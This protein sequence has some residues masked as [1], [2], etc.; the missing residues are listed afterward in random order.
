MGFCGN[1]LVHENI[2]PRSSELLAA[3]FI[4][5]W[6]Q[7][8][9]AR[10]GCLF[11]CKA[12]QKTCS[13]L[14]MNHLFDQICCRSGRQNID[15]R[16]MESIPFFLFEKRRW[17]ILPNAPANVLVSIGTCG[18]VLI[19][20][21]RRGDHLPPPHHPISVAL[22]ILPS[23]HLPSTNFVFKLCYPGYQRQKGKFNSGRLPLILRKIRS[24]VNL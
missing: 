6:S 7:F 5:R 22:R 1:N 10:V 21:G 4:Q 9:I 2:E 20:M 17:A 24:D 11:E 15:E 12:L 3:E 18:W 19:F 23:W 16:R 13:C 14:S 8:L